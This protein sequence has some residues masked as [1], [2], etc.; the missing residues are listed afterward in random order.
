MMPAGPIPAGPVGRHDLMTAFA[1][2]VALRTARRG[3]IRPG[4]REGPERPSPHGPIVPLRGVP[5]RSP[6]Q[7]RL[8]RRLDL[9][10]GA[11]ACMPA[12]ARPRGPG[13][14]IAAEAGR[15]RSVIAPVVSGL[16]PG[17]GSPLCPGM[18]HGPR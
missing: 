13:A 1:E 9:V 8:I 4:A 7:R 2:I 10:A 17:K 12:I 3:G 15:P 5:A 16:A 11:C 6:L 14:R 18:D